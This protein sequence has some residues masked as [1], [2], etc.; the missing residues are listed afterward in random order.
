MV[1]ECFLCSKPFYS[2]Y[3]LDIH[4]VT[5]TGEKPF[6]CEVCGNRF[7]HKGSLDRHNR[8]H[9]GEKPFA[10]SYCEKRFTTK[11]NLKVHLAIR[12]QTIATSR[13]HPN[14]YSNARVEELQ[15]NHEHS[16]KHENI[17]PNKNDVFRRNTYGN[18]LKKIQL[19]RMFEKS[20]V[21]KDE[22]KK[23]QNCKFCFEVFG[24]FPKEDFNEDGC[25]LPC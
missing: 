17:I 1:F 24:S 8:I 3:K 23:N 13:G 7:A 4:F 11:S 2:R 18:T 6:K 14:A 9:T 5:H 20:S 10:C 25:Y 16:E 22:P 19:S 15:K 21:K 12:H